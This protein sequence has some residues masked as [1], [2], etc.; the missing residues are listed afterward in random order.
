MAYFERHTVSLTTA[1]GGGVT[2]YTPVVTGKV[3]SCIYTKTDFAAGVVFLITGEASGQT[4]WTET[5]VDASETLNPRQPIH[6]NAG[7]ALFYEAANTEAI[8]DHIVVAN[9]RIKVVI[10]SGGDTKTGAITFIVG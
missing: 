8:S 1:A 3:I 10:A 9:E 7:A 4:I 6:D 5:A 2:A